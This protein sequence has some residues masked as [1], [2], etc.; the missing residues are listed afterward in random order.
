MIQKGMHV[1][2]PIIL[3]VL[4]VFSLAGCRDDSTG[5]V[6]PATMQLTALRI[7]TSNLLAN[8]EAPQPV[9]KS[10][11]LSFS[12]AL[13]ETT[14][15]SSI[16]LT[17]ENDQAVELVFSLLDS[18]KTI[19]ITHSEELAINSTYTLSISKDIKGAEGETFPGFQVTFLTENPPMV[20]SS[21]TIDGASPDQ[22]QRIINIS[23]L[24]VF[25][26]TFSDPLDLEELK[27]NI[28]L[29]GGSI[30]ATFNVT[31]GASDSTFTMTVTENLEGYERYSLFISSALTSISGKKFESY[32]LPFYTEL[33]SSLKFPEI[34]DEALLTKVQ[35]QTFKYFWDFGHPVSG[36]ARERNTSGE[37]VTSGGSGFGLM[38]IIVGIERGFI[39]REEGVARLN[40]IITFL[41]EESD[42]FH[43][44]WSHWLNGTSGKVIPFS[45]D[46]DGGDLVETSFMVQGLLTVR[47]Y[48]DSSHPEEA[49]LIA[50]IN[51]L[52][53]G[54][55]WDWYTQ[56]GQDV[57][58]WH[59]SP[60]VGW[61][62]NHKISGWNEA[63]M[64]YVL[65]AAS[66]THPIDQEVYTAGWARN[67]AM[68]NSSG[69][70][71][72]GYQMDLRSDK[73]GPLFFAHYSF[74]GL[75]PRNLTDQYA[76]YW[77]Q[78]VNH[79]LINRAYCI[80]NPKR[81]VGYSAQSWGLTASD[82]HEGYNAHSPDNDLG[83]ITPTAAIS[84]IPYTPEESME[85]MRHF[86]YILGDKLWGQYGFYDA[87]NISEGWTASS[88]IAIDQGPILVMI[89]NHRTG[90]LWNLFMSAPE[91]QSGLDKLGFSYE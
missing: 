5:G 9:D 46:D 68:V 76:N 90:L 88:Y 70:S 7:G 39:T 52:W 33:D 62:K 84:S 44:A 10:I 77:N 15:S 79:T 83:V 6:T 61:Q 59:W 35:E 16:T 42:R 45:S 67:G 18:D 66:P 41:D 85:A 19:S 72:Y 34:S 91:V 50:R 69:A 58:Y 40:K 20:L 57:L 12:H 82:N 32:Q 75:D 4:F 49:D 31:N 21:V 29:S 36:L 53:E 27:D 56:D 73:G 8:P 26:L 74:L 78:N 89:E 43:G 11:I 86:Y 65:A 13:S 47:Q 48:L 2:T 60:N 22:N 30:P 17:N 14:I 54:V 87:F 38:G 55:E 28:N 63:L 51:S 71:Y 1:V 25:Q 80:A 3:V 64:V 81:F 24:P 37:T 23:R